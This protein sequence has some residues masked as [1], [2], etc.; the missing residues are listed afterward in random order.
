MKRMRYR[1]GLFLLLLPAFGSYAQGTDTASYNFTLKQAVDYAIQNQSSIK[2]AM[3]DEQ[4]ATHK[5]RE[6]TGIGLPQISSSF[7]MKDFFEI[8]TSLI[9]GE[10]FGGQA[11]TF[12]PVKFGTQYNATAGISASQLVF[13]G[14]Y[15]IGL[16]AAKVYQELS[17][18]QTERTRTETVVT[19]TK[20]YYTVLVNEER[21]RLLQAN[22]DQ[23]KKIM[24]D[25]KAFNEKGF[26]EKLDYDRVQVA[27]NNLITEQ[28]KITRLMELGNALLKYQIGMDQSAKLTVTDK[29]ADVSFQ[30]MVSV[31]EKTNYENR[32]EYGLMQLQLKGYNLQLRKDQFGRLPS[33]ALYGSIQA[34]AQRSEFD[35]LDNKSQPWYPIGVIGMQVNMPIFSGLTTHQRIQQDRLQVEKAKNDLE[36]MQRTIDLDMASARTQLQ[37]ASQAL[38]MQKANIDLAQEIFNTSKKKYD[39]GVGSNLEVLSAETAL[40]EAQ[41]NY[42]NALYEAVVAK[43]DYDRATGTIK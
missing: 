14:G 6:I 15:I 37:N 32:P 23:L 35:F 30:P 2:N 42:F 1:L 26:V 11:G 43:V 28:Q 24:E 22:V 39:A 34:Q 4:I 20:A 25:T 12:I 19:V 17:H 8:P 7:D 9:P 41:T 36:F 31:A 10:F 29:I 5:V 18:K 16:K 40:K 38:E 3:L 13:D 21:L 27:Y 33:I